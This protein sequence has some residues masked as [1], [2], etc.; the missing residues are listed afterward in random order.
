MVLHCNSTPEDY[1]HR[2]TQTLYN[3]SNGYILNIL[4]IRKEHIRKLL[5]LPK[6]TRLAIRVRRKITLIVMVYISRGVPLF[7][8]TKARMK[9]VRAKMAPMI[10]QRQSV[11]LRSYSGLGTAHFGRVAR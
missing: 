1:G 9:R 11:H 10:V 7:M 5:I 2:F 4:N 6:S 8:K 3:N